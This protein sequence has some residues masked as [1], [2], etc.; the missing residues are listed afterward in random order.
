MQVREKVEKSRNILFCQWFVAPEGRKVGS[1]KAAGAEPSGQMRDEN[2]HAAV[3]R[4][5]FGSKNVQSI[6]K[7]TMPGPLLEVEMS[8]KCTPLWRE[9]HFKV[10]MLKAPH[11]QTAVESSDVV[12]RGRRPLPKVSK[13]WGLCSISKKTMA[14]VEHLIKMHFAWQMQY[15]RRSSEMLEGQGADFLRR[16]AFWSIRSSGLLRWF[17]VT[18][19]ALRMTWR[20]F[21]VAGAAL[22]TDGADKSQNTLIRGRQ[23]CTQL[24]M[25]EGSLAELLSFSCSQLQKLRMSR[26]IAS[27]L[28]LSS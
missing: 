4:S 12:L 13:T 10:K 23:L 27:F 21:C 14:G 22:Y 26:R 5:T 8:K 19:A 16:V 9:A 1:L 25:F 6:T 28:T 7:H 15:K 11:A 18:G 24:S 17:C 2:L 3:A 20:H